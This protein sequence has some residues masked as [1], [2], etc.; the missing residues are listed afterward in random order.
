MGLFPRSVHALEFEFAKVCHAGKPDL[1]RDVFNLGE[2][3]LTADQTS[4]R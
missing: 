3:A 4:T 2:F 1:E